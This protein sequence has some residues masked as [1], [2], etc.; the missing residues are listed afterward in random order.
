M[1]LSQYVIQSG[2][3]AEQ[4]ALGVRMQLPRD[5]LALEIA[6]HSTG[7]ND[8]RIR[9]HGD[10]GSLP[11]AA[12]SFDLV[13]CRSPSSGIADVEAFLMEVSRILKPASTL[14]IEDLAAPDDRKAADY[15]NAFERLCCPGHLTIYPVY[16]W[17]GMLLNAG[18]SIEYR[19]MERQ[20]ENLAAWAKQAGCSDARLTR[21]HILLA[22]APTAVARFLNPT[23]TGTPDAAFDHVRFVMTGRKS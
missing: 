12:A 18:L 5:G 4:E 10:T 19:A 1:L 3:D 11:Y 8:S 21:L 22:Q 14:L 23:C 7:V 16:R 15:V 20:R 6:A 13:I 2:R 17:E 9:V